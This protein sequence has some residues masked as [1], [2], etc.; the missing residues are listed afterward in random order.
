MLIRH[1]EKP[2]PTNGIA[3]V[4]VT[5]K[6]DHRELSVT[7]WQ[8]TGALLSLFDPQG[9]FVNLLARPQQIIAC[10]PDL[11]SARSL[12]TVRPLAD[13][14]SISV[15]TRYGDGEEEALVASLEGTTGVVLVSW[16][17]QG[18]PKLAEL[19]AKGQFLTPK[20]WP[21]ERFDIIWIFER[22]AASATWRFTQIPQQL[23][24]TDREDVLPQ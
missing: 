12:Q 13:R 23:L 4:D 3:G 15:D 8:R 22:T 18:L 9:E 17:H 2:D 19:L 11:K 1:A 6:A 5:G 20:M 10:R 7:G 16:K 24:A 21:P 14:L